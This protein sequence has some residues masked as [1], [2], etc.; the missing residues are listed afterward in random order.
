MRGWQC[1]PSVR[2]AIDWATSVITLARQEREEEERGVGTLCSRVSLQ[3][4]AYQPL[5]RR[6]LG[7]P[8][9][10]AWL[11]SCFSM[12]SVMTYP[13]HTALQVMPLVAT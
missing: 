8:R 10:R 6:T 9:V 12:S 1:C 2:E 5:P 7:M 4:L 3:L 11:S 13:G